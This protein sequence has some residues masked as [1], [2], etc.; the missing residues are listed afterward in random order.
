MSAAVQT[1]DSVPDVRSERRAPIEDKGIGRRRDDPTRLFERYRR[2]GARADRDELVAR[3]MP[4]A[5]HLARRY[6]TRSEDEDVLQVAAI[7]LIKAIDRFDP[8]R[9]IAF[10]S[11]AVP[12]ILGEIK[13]HFRDLGWS[14]RVPRPLQEL[15]VRVQRATEDLTARLGRSPTVDELADACGAPAEE[16][17]EARALG[18][19]HHA[20]SLDA[21]AHDDEEHST[22]RQLV[23]EEDP[24]YGRAELGADLERLLMRLDERERVV[25]R[26]RFKEDLV[27]REIARRLGISQ[28]QVSRIISHAISGLQ[29]PPHLT[30]DRPRVA[31][32]R[33]PA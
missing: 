13:R 18:T 29:Q 6:A 10:S 1:R 9:G 19:A 4:L 7:G 24:G 2:E 33:P 17:L 31:L 27:Q 20:I 12:T 23:G 16:I 25:L 11:F 15:G 14:V 3:Y 26:L 32:H 5:Q 22:P 8:H 21:L 30:G 28:M